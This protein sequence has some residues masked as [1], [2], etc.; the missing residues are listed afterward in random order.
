M[1]YL[2]E[3]ITDYQKVFIAGLAKH[4]RMNW[5]TPLQRAKERN[6][7]ARFRGELQGG[8]GSA[9]RLGHASS[10]LQ[11]LA[12]SYSGDV[13]VS[14]YAD[15]ETDHVAISAGPHGGTKVTLWSGPVSALIDTEVRSDQ[16][17]RLR[18]QF[19]AGKPL[20]PDHEGE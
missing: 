1:V 12:Q 10:G 16:L 15:G 9:S 14:L 13:Q 2:L 19:L 11:V 5:F 6:K 7:M 17:H 8:R 20:N 4:G 3:N 18:M